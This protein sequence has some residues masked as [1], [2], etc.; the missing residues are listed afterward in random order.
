[1]FLIALIFAALIFAGRRSFPLRPAITLALLAAIGA[2][3][4]WAVPLRYAPDALEVTAID[5]GQGDA[6]LLMV[7]QASGRPLALMVD[8]GGPAGPN[9]DPQAGERIG[10]ED[11]SNYL[12]A[13]GLR[14]LDAIALTHAHTDH[15]GGMPAVIRNFHP[16]ELW[17]GTNPSVQN[18]EDLLATAA[19]QH[20]TTRSMHAGDAFAFGSSQITV[21]SPSTEYTPGAT[22]QNEDSLV[23]RIAFSG[24]TAQLEGDAQR[25]SEAGMVSRGLT[26]ID[27]LKVGHHGSLSSTTPGFLAALSPN[28]AVISAGHD[29]LYGHPREPILERLESAHAQ[30]FRTDEDGTITFLLRREGVGVG[31]SRRTLTTACGR[32]APAAPCP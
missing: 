31:I 7:P 13:R 4:F 20:V 15:M 1:M 19:A 30:T 21:L 27:L 10:E 5:V 16:R 3:A 14:G 11:V 26:H 22:P 12:W 28:F 2:L 8:S 9:G 23:L 17:V 25:V 29:N 18:Y 24:R 6:L 32:Q